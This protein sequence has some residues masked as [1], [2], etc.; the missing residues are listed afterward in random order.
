MQ[1]PT[2]M[3]WL[4]KYSR[5]RFILFLLLSRMLEQVIMQLPLLRTVAVVLRRQISTIRFHY[6]GEIIFQSDWYTLTVSRSTKQR[7]LYNV[8]PCFL[9]MLATWLKTLLM[10]LLESWSW[11]ESSLCNSKCLLHR[12]QM[13]FFF[14]LSMLACL[15]V[16]QSLSFFVTVMF[17]KVD[18]KSLQPLMHHDRQP[19]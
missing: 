7:A 3:S 5:R 11:R 4:T 9:G 2:K 6:P 13:L 17:L 15:H 1:M 18:N 12:K 8:F 19:S 14:L 10:S 16:C